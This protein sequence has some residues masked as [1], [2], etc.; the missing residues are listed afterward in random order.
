M[1]P[2]DYQTMM[3]TMRETGVGQAAVEGAWWLPAVQPFVMS[4]ADY[5]QLTQIGR[6]LFLFTDAVS[7]EL[8]ENPNGA[9][10]QR[11]HEKVPAHIAQTL[12]FA[13]V[14]MFRPDLQ[15]VPTA[16]GL[17]FVLTEIEIAPFSEGCAHAMQLAYGV[18]ADIVS[19]FATMLN[20]RELLF[21][22]THEWNQYQFDQLAFC[23][24][25]AEHGIRGR[26]LY[27]RTVAQMEAEI[28]RGDRWQELI[29]DGQQASM[30]G[31]IARYQLEP[32]IL[33]EW[34]DAVGDAVV[35]RFGYV[36]HFTTAQ[37]ELFKR[38]ETAGATFLNPFSYHLDSKVM[39]EG[40]RTSAIRQRLKAETVAVLERCIPE[41]VLLT[42]QN[43]A[44]F[45]AEKDAW[46]I[47]FAGFDQ[48]NTAWGGRSVRFG[49]DFSAETWQTLLQDSLTLNW[50]V[51]AQRLA[52]S[53]QLTLD[54]YLPDGTIATQHQGFTRLRTFFLRDDSADMN[55]VHCGSH[56][57]V[58]RTM[59]VSEAALNA[60][61]TPVQF[62][63][64]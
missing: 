57:T 55:A 29:A 59:N 63:M 52:T 50:P 13:P 19:A 46:L 25:L 58:N 38:W 2:N 17:Q 32:F 16:N 60:I 61:Q 36:E 12:S 1:L 7:A 54:Y 6:A 14:L 42:A 8:R 9:F 33:D 21:V 10:A 43:Q 4:S 51:V 27:D 41:T 28:E 53:Q 39:M 34:P 64:N 3:T 40:V 49:R 15:L 56:I 48:T 26:V 23:K 47:K 35:F 62:V 45:V 31:H 22:G 5:Q 18:S 37:H 44:Q 11:L 24:A 20:G 30:T